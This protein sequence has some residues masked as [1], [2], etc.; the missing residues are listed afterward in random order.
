MHFMRDARLD[1]G[2]VDGG[3]LVAVVAET[4]HRAVLAGRIR[5]TSMREE[6]CIPLDYECELIAWRI[7]TSVR[8]KA[9]ISDSG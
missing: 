9:G 1:D 4:S 7:A 3:G 6:E 2:F 8:S 5:R